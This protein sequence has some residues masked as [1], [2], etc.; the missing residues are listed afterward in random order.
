M[1]ARKTSARK[2][3]R[4]SPAKKAA[5]KPSAPSGLR[6]K[7][8]AGHRISAKVAA[9]LTGRHREAVVKATK[10]RRSVKP[11]ELGGAFDKAEVTAILERTDA[12]YLRFYY[13][14]NDQGGRELVLVASDE[15]GNDLVDTALDSHWPCPPFCPPD[16]SILRG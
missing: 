13:G 12:A 5:K 9:K 3:T 11:G 10:G 15:M 7:G 2:A 4:K 8:K 16:A 1:A 14:T 6:K